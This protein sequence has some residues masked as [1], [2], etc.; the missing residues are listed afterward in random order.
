MLR[1]MRYSL[2]PV[3]FEPIIAGMF[4]CISAINPLGSLTLTRKSLYP[5]KAGFLNLSFTR[6]TSKDFFISLMAF[7]ISASLLTT[8]VVRSKSKIKEASGFFVPFSVSRTSFSAALTMF[9]IGSGLTCM[10]TSLP[11]RSTI[12]SNA[13]FS[14][15]ARLM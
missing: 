10:P 6:T 14:C 12:A 4:T 2:C 5:V 1:D 13:G 15:S 3:L 9:L 11:M 8:I 7:G